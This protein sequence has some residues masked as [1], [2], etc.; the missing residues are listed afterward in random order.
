MDILNNLKIILECSEK[1]S[2][3]HNI[4]NMSGTPRK[5]N[6]PPIAPIRPNLPINTPQPIVL[7][8]PI[9]NKNNLE[10]DLDEL[11]RHGIFDISKLVKIV[12]EKKIVMS[13]TMTSLTI[14]LT[15]PREHDVKFNTQSENQTYINQRK[16]LLEIQS[17]LEQEK[18]RN[19]LRQ[20]MQEEIAKLPQSFGD[21]S[22]FRNLTPEQFS[23]VMEKLQ[24]YINFNKRTTSL[25]SSKNKKGKYSFEPEMFDQYLINMYDILKPNFEHLARSVQP[26]Q[27]QEQPQS[28]GWSFG[29]LLSSKNARKSIK[30]SKTPRGN[31]TPRSKGSKTPRGKTPRAKTTGGKTTKPRSTK[32][33]SKGSNTSILQYFLSD[34]PRF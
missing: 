22:V 24:P 33:R 20:Q 11:I 29:G 4:G 28:S 13:R 31:N 14:M 27:E 15:D 8:S 23:K 7:S 3:G 1:K 34:Q 30:K 12:A 9:I 16:S 10:I 21:P 19:A 17:T 2:H 6:T 32:P 25:K 26:V 5:N 18:N